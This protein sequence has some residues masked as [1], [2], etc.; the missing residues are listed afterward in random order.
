[1][2]GQLAQRF[3]RLEQSLT[4]TV[5]SIQEL[6]HGD[7]DIRS[8]GEQNARGQEEAELVTV[9]TAALSPAPVKASTTKPQARPTKPKS[10]IKKK[11]PT[12][13]KRLPAGLVLLRDFAGKHHVVTERASKAGETGKITVVQG[14]WLVNSRWATEALDVQGQQEFYQHFHERE[15]FT[16]CEQCPHHLAS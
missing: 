16:A 5:S 1:M 15:G 10:S 11:K 13:G 7:M 3:D 4:Q 14:K 9:P 8:N 12:R 2:P 6:L